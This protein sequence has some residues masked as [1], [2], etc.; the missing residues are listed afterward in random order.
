VPPTEQLQRHWGEIRDV[1]N[2]AQLERG[3]RSLANLLDR[4]SIVW[5]EGFHLPQQIVL[6]AD[7]RRLEFPM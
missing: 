7:T 4:Q 5:V 1:S 3:I 6:S 2:A